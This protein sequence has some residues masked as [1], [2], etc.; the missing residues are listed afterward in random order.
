MSNHYK[1]AIIGCGQIAARH[2]EQIQKNGQLIAVCDIKKTTANDFSKR[3]GSKVYYDIDD[4]LANEKQIDIVSVCTPNGL[5][6]SHSMKSLLAGRHVLCEKP[7]AIL[8]ADAKQMIETERQ[9]A[10]RLFI[11]KQNRF[12]PPVVFVRQLINE[13][14][15][16]TIFS[17][18]LNC[19][20]NRPS[21]YY[22]SSWKGTKEMDGGILFTQFSHF[23]DLLYW[24]LGDI[25]AAKG[26]RQNF[27]HKDCIEFEDTGVA[28]L[29][30]KNGAVG[31]INYTINS[32]QKNMEGSL[33]L[34]GEKGTV[35]IG[36]QYLNEL[37]Y[38]LV[39]GE[40]RPSFAESKPANEY[41]FYQ[42]SMSNHDKVY[43]ELIKAV[44]DPEH[45]FINSDETLKTIEMIE[46]IYHSSPLI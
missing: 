36:G 40:T 35:K 3:Y 44:G 6:A 30:M 5:H 31:T 42:G 18:Q 41:G 2:A 37:E 34:F 25:D 39:Q 43:E 24:L 32:L 1:F 20:W 19:F 7:M 38:F 16:G 21:S 15:L 11:V 45:I 10:K 14:K 46:K 12:N 28:Y 22:K 4:L 27:L 23:I 26:L 8:S 9:T 33:T 17:F 29:K 13:K